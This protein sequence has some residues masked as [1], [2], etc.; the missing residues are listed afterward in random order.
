M[1]K[2]KMGYSF[3]TVDTYDRCPR[4]LCF[5]KFD[6]RTKGLDRP[7]V[8]RDRGSVGHEVMA[9]YNRELIASDKGQD[10]ELLKA[11]AQRVLKEQTVLPAEH[12]ESVRVMCET[13]AIAQGGLPTKAVIEVEGRHP[14]KSPGRL[15][16][17]L[18]HVNISREEGNGEPFV[19]R[20]IRD[21]VWLEGDHGHIRDYKTTYRV[22]TQAQT[23]ESFQLR[24]YAWVLLLQYP[25]LERVT[26]EFLFMPDGIIRR[27]DTA[28]W[29]RDDLAFVEDDLRAAMERIEN[30]ET[31]RAVP[32]SAC[33]YCDYPEFCEAKD[34]ALDESGVVVVSSDDE[35]SSVAE[36]VT[37][38][39]RLISAREDALKA[40]AETHGDI[41]AGDLEYGFKATHSR[42]FDAHV[43]ASAVK[44]AGGDPFDVLRVDARAIDR[45]VKS[46]DD[47][48][49]AA[50]IEAATSE[51]GYSRWGSRKAQG[52]GDDA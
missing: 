46:S 37:M 36:E 14:A 16:D 3:T 7:S 26:P 18:F 25:E 23:N 8:P 24:V 30:D 48:A 21:L 19:F 51:S 13:A 12:F 28:P 47:P 33:S 38:L 11:V 29:T 50:A 35:A 4:S 44:R 2:P 20:G 34:R 10:L 43:V 40:W 17:R 32:G 27:P 39:K 52:G 5:R 15:W 49:L 31:Y 41:I 22:A 45:L 6:P 9:A 1:S 42:R